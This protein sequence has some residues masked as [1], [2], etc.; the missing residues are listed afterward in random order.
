MVAVA[1]ALGAGAVGVGAAGPT[2]TAGATPGREAAEDWTLALGVPAAPADGGAEA[3]A[4]GGGG[5][6]RAAE[7]V[8]ATGDVLTGAGAVAGAG[9]RFGAGLDVGAVLPEV[10]RAPSGTEG[11]PPD[12]DVT[13]VVVPVGDGLVTTGVP[14]VFVTGRGA[15]VVAGAGLDVGAADPE[16]EREPELPEPVVPE[17][18]PDVVPDPLVA[19]VVGVHEPTA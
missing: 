7:D 9:V 4:A 10:V 14:E 5:D 3:E 15:T 11:A 1:A 17:D 12:E 13:D 19:P 16:P 18:V 8:L 6:M 2:A